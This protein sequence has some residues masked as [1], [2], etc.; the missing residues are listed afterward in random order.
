MSI[1]QRSSSGSPSTIQDA[2]WRPIPPAPAMP[3]AENPAATKK[4]PTSDSPR[5]NSLSGVKPSGPLITR[6]TPASAIAGTRRMAPFHD[7][8]E[9]VHVGRQE[10]AVEVGRDAVERPRRGIALVATHAQPADLLAEVD[11]VVGVAQLRQ[12]RVDALDRLGEEV[13]VGH[14]DDRHGDADHPADLR[15]EHAAGVDDD[16][17]ADLGPFALVLDGHAGDPAAVRADADDAGLGPDPGAPLARSRG[18]RVGEPGRI[19]PAVGRQPD[20][21]EDAV[22]RHQREA[23]LRLLRRD[24]LEREAERLGPARLPAQLLEPFRAWTQAAASRPRATTGPCRSRRR[25]AGTGRTRTSSS[26]SGSPS[27]AAGRPGRPSG[28]SIRR[29]VRRGRPGRCRSSRARR[30]GRR[31]SSRRRRRR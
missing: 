12:A 18:E 1:F 24:E 26:W 13:L 27:R 19:E 14:R 20:R 11:E 22:G 5:M 3:C 31:C 17:G 7:R 25:D 2:I 6:L 30:G 10:L 21:A 9:A 16:V 8:L 4:P 15:G 29:S 28:R 23:V